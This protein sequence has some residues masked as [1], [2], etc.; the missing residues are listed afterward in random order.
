MSR[1]C[2]LKL[3]LVLTV[4]LLGVRLDGGDRSAQAAS[5]HRDARARQVGSLATPW[6]PDFD[7][8]EESARKVIHFIGTESRRLR[9]MKSTD[10]GLTWSSPED[11]GAGW[12]ARMATDSKGNVHLVYGTDPRPNPANPPKTGRQASTGWYRVRSSEGWSAP[13]PLAAPV[14]DPPVPGAFSHRIAVDGNDNVHVT[15]YVWPADVKKFSWKD[16]Q[17]TVYVRKPA[18]AA[19]EPLVMLRHGK[20]ASGGGAIA[21]PVVD[22]NGDVHLIYGSWNGSEWR[23]TH[24]VRKK[25]GSWEDKIHDW[26]QMTSDYSMKTAIGPDG[27]IH[28][29]GF[30]DKT[31]SWIYCNNRQKPDVM[32]V[33]HVIEDDWEVDL[34]I[35][36]TPNNDVWMSR[37]NHYTDEDPNWPPRPGGYRDNAAYYVHFDATT[38]IWGPRTRLSPPGAENSD[39]TKHLHAPKFIYYDGSVRIFYAERKGAGDFKYYQR[40]LSG[41]R[42]LAQSSTSMKHP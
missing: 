36:V 13:A 4:C 24:V 7:V 21:D 27:V 33:L 14:M 42:P 11:L 39:A 38:S 16:L 5:R 15:Y 1:L 8:V 40:T 22:R 34:E 35:L 2:S 32:K 9:Y 41:P 6:H 25:D 37:D 18:G 29:A 28:V 26:F 30:D 3:G 17:R 19:F 31:L 12:A 20:D 10:G 23:T